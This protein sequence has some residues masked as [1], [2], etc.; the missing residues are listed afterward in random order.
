MYQGR[1]PQGGIFRAERHFPL[2]N[3]MSM[4]S[5]LLLCEKIPQKNSSRRR[6][7]VEDSS[8]FQRCQTA[9]KGLYLTVSCWELQWGCYVTGFQLVEGQK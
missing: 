2:E 3:V 4:R 7:E 9:E 5:S 1:F 6:Q 8:T